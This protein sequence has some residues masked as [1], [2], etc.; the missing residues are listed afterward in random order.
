MTAP[1]R[2]ATV[3]PWSV[4]TPLGVSLAVVLF[5]ATVGSVGVGFG[6][7]TNCT[8]THSCTATGC[9]PCETTSAWLT[10]G[11]IGQG[12]LLL[13]GIALVVLAALHRRL[14]AVR[15]GALVLGPLSVALVVVTTALAVAAI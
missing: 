13:A 9:A 11:W 6:V 5:L 2:P 3:R 1:G 8:N 12:V 4:W 14:R 7:M 15:R 10:A